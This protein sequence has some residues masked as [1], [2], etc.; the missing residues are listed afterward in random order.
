MKRKTR[1]GRLRFTNHV[2]RFT[3][4]YA[5]DAIP[6]G[7]VLMD[8]IAEIVLGYADTLI[9]TEIK[10][11]KILDYKILCYRDD[12]RIFVDSPAQGSEIVKIISLGLCGSELKLS[13]RPSSLI[14]SSRNQSR[15]TRWIG[16]RGECSTETFRNILSGFTILASPI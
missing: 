6:Q 16:L 9:T 3:N 11:A 14:Q 15:V 2:L 12:Y 1:T 10:A 13:S 8:F 7:S 4:S 5:T